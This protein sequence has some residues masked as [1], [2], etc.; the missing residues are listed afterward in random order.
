LGSKNLRSAFAIR[1][2]RR[3]YRQKSKND[4]HL[5]VAVLSDNEAIG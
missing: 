2:L 1:L 4:L 5:L 3:R